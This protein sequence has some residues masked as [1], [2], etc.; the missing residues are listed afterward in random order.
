MRNSPVNLAF[1]KS[2]M[3]LAPAAKRTSSQDPALVFFGSPTFHLLFVTGQIDFNPR[4]VSFTQD[5]KGPWRS[6]EVI[7][8]S[9]EI[10]DSHILRESLCQGPHAPARGP[11]CGAVTVMRLGLV[12][13]TRS[14]TNH[15][16]DKLLPAQCSRTAQ[17]NGTRGPVVHPSNQGDTVC[18]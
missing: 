14:C 6:D 9:R 11:V 1:S 8:C 7:S 15:L 12:G 13:P 3:P 4:P 17:H 2:S 10:R 18:R 5:S 16:L